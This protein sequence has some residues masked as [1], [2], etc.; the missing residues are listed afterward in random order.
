MIKGEKWIVNSVCVIFW[1]IIMDTVIDDG[2]ILTKSDLIVLNS[3]SFWHSKF[4]IDCGSE[5]LPWHSAKVPKAGPKW[6]QL[7]IHNELEV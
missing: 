5:K 4:V 6:Q 2:I 7:F 3:Y 1:A